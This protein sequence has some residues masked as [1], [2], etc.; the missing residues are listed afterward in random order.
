[1]TRPRLAR[2]ATELLA[3]EPLRVGPH[4]VAS[5]TRAI[6]AMEARIRARARRRRNVRVAG[7]VAIAASLSL[8]I[9]HAAR[10]WMAPHE[11]ES[12]ADAGAP[13]TVAA[14]AVEPTKG[15]GLVHAGVTSPLEGDARLVPGDRLVAGP[16]GAT[17]LVL[18][19]GSR[20]Q[21]DA[22]SDV[23]ITSLSHTRSFLV[24]K[25]ALRADVRKLG[26][27]ERFIVKTVDA[28]VEVRGTSFRVAVLGAPSP[29]TPSLTRVHVYEG[30]VAVRGLDRED[31]VISGED[32]PKGCDDTTKGAT[33]SGPTAR[34]LP[35]VG[36]TSAPPSAAPPVIASAT[37]AAPPP[38]APAVRRGSGG[39]M[40]PDLSLAEQN[41]LLGEATAARRRGDYAA[42]IAAYDRLLAKRPG[43]FVAETAEVERMRTLESIDRQQAREAARAYLAGYPN[44]FA[45]ADAERLLR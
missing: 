39:A 16:S 6:A 5:E 2:L 41:Q 7:G 38:P 19:D 21:V 20:L 29:C 22:E 9:G 18:A 30:V 11:A 1:M 15:S 34:P 33:L 10:T 36:S 13:L 37:P 28:E 24:S 4:S 26:A 17:G 27:G 25:G 35:A 44:G 14:T 8:A 45:R 3:E 23:S 12:L 40:K 31:R 32:W 42:A 43:G